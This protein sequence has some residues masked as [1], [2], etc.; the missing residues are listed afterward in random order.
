MCIVC[1][2]I[3]FQFPDLLLSKSSVLKDLYWA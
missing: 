1:Q 2:M 3:L